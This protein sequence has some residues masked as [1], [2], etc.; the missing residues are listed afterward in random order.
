VDS[1]VTK[2]RLPLQSPEI[3]AQQPGLKLQISANARGAGLP[4]DKKTRTTS[5]HPRSDGMVEH[6]VKTV[7]EHLRR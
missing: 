2:L 4:V 6:Y 3:A 1:L 7:E 5:L